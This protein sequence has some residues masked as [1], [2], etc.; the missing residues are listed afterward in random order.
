MFLKNPAGEK[1]ITLKNQ[2][3]LSKYPKLQN[4]DS[5]TVVHP[6][7]IFLIEFLFHTADIFNVVCAFTQSFFSWKKYHY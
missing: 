1:E 6:Y 7:N 4:F 5:H 2:Q 3:L